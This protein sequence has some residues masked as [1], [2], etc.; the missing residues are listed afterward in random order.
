MGLTM[1]ER[2]ANIRELAPRFQKASKME[3]SHILDQ[4]VSL[5][6]YTR[7][8]AAFV[9]RTCGKRQLK[10]LD[11]GT[12]R[13]VFVAG[14]CRK[15]GAE[16]RR[17]RQYGGKTFLT[18]LRQLWSLS[19][20]LCGKRLVAFIREV[21]PLLERQRALTLTDDGLR[22]KL[23]TVSPATIDRL[24]TT[25][26]AQARLKGRSGTRPGTLLKHHIPIRTFADWNDTRP[27]FCEADLVA[28][29]GGATFGE[30]CQ[31]LSLT[32]V[33][34]AWME[35]KAVKNKAQIYVF[36]ALQEIRR[37][38]PFGLLGL[39]SDNGSEF[40]NDQLYRYCIS[41][42]ITFTRS[43]AYHKNDNCY[44]EQKNYSIVR[45]TVGY[46]RYD[47]PEHLAML[48]AFYQVFRLYTNFFQPVMKLAEKVRRGSRVT[49]RYDTPQ[50]PY[51]RVLAHPAI[52]DDIKTRLRA[53]YQ[54]LNI[55]HLKGELN[56]IQEQL[57]H[58]AIT[59]GPPPRP[60][61]PCYP[62][63]DHPWRVSVIGSKHLLRKQQHQ[64]TSLVPTDHHQSLASDLKI[65]NDPLP[66]PPNSQLT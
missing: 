32:D 5:T 39:D 10:I 7:C 61:L 13:V 20:G 12:R 60:P 22:Q 40:I 41:Q 31:T 30:Y 56:R 1:Q 54:Q 44:I 21:L 37:E 66:E 25:T 36:Q 29:D 11:G 18:A 38:L 46:Y 16:R 23:L 65:H 6:G 62:P 14:Y 3:R 43:R 15:A 27:G 50:T 35:M 33:A 4:F 63:D 64:Q 42:Q 28:H 8:Y 49:R 9:L 26:R 59:A 17:R 51:H 45:K 2:H 24:L 19:D 52:P 48:T 57:F 53:Q 47:R 34:T 55:V 58:S